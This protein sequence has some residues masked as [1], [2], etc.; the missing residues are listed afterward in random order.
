[1]AHACWSH[2]RRDDCAA[3]RLPRAGR[4]DGR[5]RS[6]RRRLHPRPGGV[7]TSKGYKGFPA[8]I[9][10]SPNSMVVHGIPG[11]YRAQEGELHLIRHRRHLRRAD[12]RLG[13]DLRGRRDL[14]RGAAAAR[15]LPGRARGRDRGGASRAVRR[16]HLPGGPDGRRGG[17]VLRDQEPRRPRRRAPLPRGSAGAELRLRLPG[18]GAEGRHDDRDRADDHGRRPRTCTSTTTSGRSRPPTARWR[19]ISSTRSP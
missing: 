17:R 12:R 11:A 19:R 15:R 9:C 18:P 4:D 2:R 3:A 10:I 1:M 8:A 5:A 6:H 16:R 7:P 13:G 14:E